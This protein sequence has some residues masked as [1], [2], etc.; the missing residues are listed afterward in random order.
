[1]RI[2]IPSSS[3]SLVELYQFGMLGIISGVI[4]MIGWAIILFYAA[5]FFARKPSPKLKCSKCGAIALS[6]NDK[7]CR[8]CG[9]PLS[10]V[11]QI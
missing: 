9:E 11:H 10:E 6:R 2:F 7:Y 5:A 4:G 3:A 1:M 8:A